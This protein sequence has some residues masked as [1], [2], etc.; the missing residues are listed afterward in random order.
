MPVPGNLITLP[1]VPLPK[2]RNMLQLVARTPVR[3]DT[4]TKATP[5]V[6][7][8]RLDE[9]HHIDDEEGRKFLS[10]SHC[11][12]LGQQASWLLISYS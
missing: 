6:G 1:D 11:Q 5:P 7:S 10:C 8:E 12:E 9:M 2:L 4:A 3:K